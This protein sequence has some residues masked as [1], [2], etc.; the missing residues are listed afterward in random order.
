[1]KNIIVLYQGAKSYTPQAYEAHS[2]LVAV[3]LSMRLLKVTEIWEAAEGLFKSMNT[4]QSS[5]YRFAMN[6]M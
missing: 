1:M 3:N 4:K 6:E 5:Q 2:A